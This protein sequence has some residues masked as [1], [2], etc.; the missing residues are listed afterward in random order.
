MQSCIYTKGEPYVKF[1]TWFLSVYPGRRRSDHSY[2]ADSV[3]RICKGPAGSGIYHFRTKKG[4]PCFNR[5]GRNQD[6]LLRTLRPSLPRA[7]DGW[8]QD[9]AIGPHQWLYQRQCWC[10]S[11]GTDLANCRRH[12]AGSQE[13]FEQKGHGYYHGSAGFPSG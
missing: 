12:K 3:Q 11:Q 1:L 2:P 13:L 9:R 4:F 6:P 8:H 5:P 10:C 7:D